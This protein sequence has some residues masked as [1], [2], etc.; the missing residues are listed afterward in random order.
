M[1][2]LEQAR[3]EIVAEFP[4]GYFLENLAVRSNG[5]ILVFAMN[6]KEL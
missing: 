3:L 1:I 4:Q 2:A 6:K 5:S